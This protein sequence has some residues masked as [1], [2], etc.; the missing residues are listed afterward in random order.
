MF[1]KCVHWPHSWE[2]VGCSGKHHIALSFLISSGRWS[3]HSLKMINRWLLMLGQIPSPL[4]SL[5]PE[6][7]LDRLPQLWSLS[8]SVFWLALTKG[9][10]KLIRGKEEHDWGIYYLGF[11]FAL[12]PTDGLSNWK[13]FF[14]PNPCNDSRLLSLWSHRWEQLLWCYLP[15]S[16]ALSQ[17]PTCTLW[18][19]SLWTLL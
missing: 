10:W 7:D 19:V 11:L 14:F 18:A 9:P 17:N 13:H 16:T 3:S 15:W 2:S 8:L 4:N 5:T 6:P 12:L 1:S